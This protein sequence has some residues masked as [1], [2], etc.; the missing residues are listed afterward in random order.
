LIGAIQNSR[1]MNKD[2]TRH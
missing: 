1:S 2:N